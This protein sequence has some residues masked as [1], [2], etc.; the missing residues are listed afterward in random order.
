[1]DEIKTKNHK[2]GRPPKKITRSTKMGFNASLV[3]HAIIRQKAKMNGVKLADYL[4]DLA[5]HGKVRRI[6]TPIEIQM[7]RDFSGTTNNLNQIAKEAHQQKLPS[8]I[9]K[10]LKTVDAINKF[11]HDYDHQD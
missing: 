2:G 4:R 9:P 3:E 8:L 6:P 5:L 7:L 10:L 1:M 11:L